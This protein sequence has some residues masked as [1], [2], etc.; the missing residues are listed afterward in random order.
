MRSVLLGYLK[1]LMVIG[2][3]IGYAVAGG[4]VVHRLVGGGIGFFVAMALVW[5]TSLLT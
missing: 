5:F 2:F 1:L 4:S 3:V